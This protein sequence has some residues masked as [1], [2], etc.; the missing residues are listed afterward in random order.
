MK[1]VSKFK[2]TIRQY[3]LTLFDRDVN[4]GG[5]QTNYGGEIYALAKQSGQYW[6]IY[7]AELN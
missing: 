4:L 6:Y 5:F 7:D 3:N 1:L 2:T